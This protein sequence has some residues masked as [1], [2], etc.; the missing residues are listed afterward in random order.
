MENEVLQAAVLENSAVLGHRQRSQFL[1]HFAIG[2]IGA[3]R[4][5][6]IEGGDA[7]INDGC[8]S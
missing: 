7:K 1:A 3:C 6:K 5:S 2:L 8:A 4:M